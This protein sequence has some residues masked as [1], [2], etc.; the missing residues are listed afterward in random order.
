[1]GYLI[2]QSDFI[3]KL[4]T[5]PEANFQGLDLTVF[6]LL[7]AT[8]LGAYNIINATLTAPITGGGYSN[9]G[10]L[11]LEN[12]ARCAVY[13]ETAGVINIGYYNT[14]AVNMS[15]PPNVFS[16]VTK[17]NYALNISS[18]L[19]PSGSGDVYIQLIYTIVNF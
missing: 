6:E 12:F 14:F 19:T 3:T 15:H 10:H 5:I 17:Q 13:D 18:Q 7:P 4:I 8:T 2:K 1:M 9:F 11:Y 16:T